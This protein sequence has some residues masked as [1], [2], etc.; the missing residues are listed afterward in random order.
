MI[1]NIGHLVVGLRNLMFEV[2][3][4]AGKNAKGLYGDVFEAHVGE[5]IA[6]ITPRHKLATELEIKR[7]VGKDKSVPDF[8]IGFA[9]K[10]LSV[11][12]Y[13][14]IP[15]ENFWRGE[16]GS[17]KRQLGEY[18]RKH[19][20]TGAIL[21]FMDK[22]AAEC[23]GWDRVTSVIRL[24]VTEEMPNFAPLITKEDDPPICP[25]RAFEKLMGLAFR[26]WGAPDLVASWQKESPHLP[27]SFYL[28]R[29]SQFTSITNW[30][31]ELDGHSIYRT[32]T[33]E[34]L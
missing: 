26:G 7:I 34:P 32:L 10:I 22:I 27:L 25:I 24:V 13:S 6:H 14:N 29:Q 31:I 11:E 19:R 33:Q 5:L 20:Q 8:L 23:F 16:V 28:D 3:T 12:V 15:N 18:R 2:L 21:P 9:G 30:R 17:I 4:K 1:T